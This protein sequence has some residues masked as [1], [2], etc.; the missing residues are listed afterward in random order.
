[1]FSLHDLRLPASSKSCLPS[2]GLLWSARWSDAD[3][4]AVPVKCQ[5]VKNARSLKMGPKRRHQIIL[6]FVTTLM[7]EDFNVYSFVFVFLFCLAV[8]TVEA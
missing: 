3:V 8:M 4:S 5:A 2:S 1:M 6:R 7:T